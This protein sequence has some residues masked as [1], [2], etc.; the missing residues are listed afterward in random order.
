MDVPTTDLLIVK[1]Y[2]PI[3]DKRKVGA[4]RTIRED[5]V[6]VIGGVVA[7]LLIAS[8]AMAFAVGTEDLGSIV[9]YDTGLI[10][11]VSDG[12]LAITNRPTSGFEVR[13]VLEFAADPPLQSNGPVY[14]NF[15]LRNLA[16]PSYGTFTLFAFSGDGAVTNDDFFRTSNPF[17]VFSDFG[18][19]PPGVPNVSQCVY[20]AAMQNVSQLGCEYTPFSID[21]R[22][23]VDSLLGAGAANLGFLIAVSPDQPVSNYDMNLGAAREDLNKFITLSNQTLDPFP[24]PPTYA[25]IPSPGTLYLVSVALLGVAATRRPK[26]SST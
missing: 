23:V 7:S 1:P 18:L 24:V 22:D 14:L 17:A 11:E 5:V 9:K 8:P 16:R 2:H 20:D 26:A 19:N 6:M 15:Y 12:A 4:M 13:V 3:P 25:S 21:V 10:G